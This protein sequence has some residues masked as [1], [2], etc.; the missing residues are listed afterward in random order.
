MKKILYLIS[1]LFA[2]ALV[3]CEEKEPATSAKVRTGQAK[4]RI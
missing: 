2:V 4:R 1:F 3:G